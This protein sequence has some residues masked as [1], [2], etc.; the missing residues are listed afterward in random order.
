MNILM[1]HLYSRVRNTERTLSKCETMGQRMI[2]ELRL[3]LYRHL[4]SLSMPF[5]RIRSKNPRV[6]G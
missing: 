4:Q 3:D 5:F 2:Y 1:P 6:W